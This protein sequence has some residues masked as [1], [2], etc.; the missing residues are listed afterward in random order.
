[1]SRWIVALASS[2]FVALCVGGCGSD[3]KQSGSLSGIDGGAGFKSGVDGSTPLGNLTP[4]QQITICRNQAAFVHA[5]VDTT[6]LMRFVCAF[7]PQVFL[8]ASD[9]ACQSAMD[10]CINSFSVK[11]DVNVNVPSS[12]TIDTVCSTVPISQCQGTV[13][14]YENCVDSIASVQLDFGTQFSCGKRADYMN[15]PTVGVNACAAVGPSCTAA[16]QPAQVR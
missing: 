12:T 7:T 8:A 1:M 16:T 13:A 3:N 14:D 2:S 10:A 6:S 15:G 4:S 9:A 11:V 5:S